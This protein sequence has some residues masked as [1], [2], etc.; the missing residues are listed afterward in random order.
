MAQVESDPSMMKSEFEE[1]LAFRNYMRDIILGAND[2]LVSI[3]ALVIG[4]AAGGLSPENVLLAG[5]AGLVAGAISMSI[6]EYLSTKSQEEI[7]DLEKRVEMEHIEH[8]LDHEKSELRE[9]YAAKGFSAELLEQIVE[10]I[11]SDP[12][13][14]LSE[15]MMAE[16]G[17]LEE[18]R[19]SPYIATTIVGIAFVIGSLPPVL[20]FL[21]VSKTSTGIFFAAILSMLSL[22][23]VG[24]I[25]ASIAKVNQYK[26]GAENMLL[27]AIGASITYLIG[28]LVGTTL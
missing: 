19:R 21:F 18:E 2:G 13:I 10:T 9:W 26:S 5:I 8:H 7:Y 28:L 20:P 6:G 14:L 16:F 3:F 15:M 4:V 12:D 24:A 25:K 22:F 11:A 27:G 1:H 17:V 23:A